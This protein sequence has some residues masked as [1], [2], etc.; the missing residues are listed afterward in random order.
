LNL[1]EI[2][3]WFASE[4]YAAFAEQKATM[5]LVVAGGVKNCETWT[6]LFGS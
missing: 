5:K 1:G 3:R 4:E 6:T 2:G